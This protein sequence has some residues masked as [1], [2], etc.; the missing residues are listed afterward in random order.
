[1]AQAQLA[2]VI[3]PSEF[4][5]YILENS[6]VS[7][8][9]FQSGVAVS[10]GEMSSQLQAGAE[11]FTVPFWSDL[12]DTEADITNDFPLP[13]AACLADHRNAPVNA[14]GYLR[15]MFAVDDI[16]ET[17]ERL[18]FGSSASSSKGGPQSKENGLKAA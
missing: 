1:M 3:V 17:L 2:D 5:A 9:L 8:A 7:T 18:S 11:S 10:N 13:H 12:P 4:S 14:L 15:V 6:M 16:D